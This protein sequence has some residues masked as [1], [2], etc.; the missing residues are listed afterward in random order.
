MCFD[1]APGWTQCPAWTW[2]KGG[3]G[4]QGASG[5]PISPTA[6]PAFSLGGSLATVPAQP[7]SDRPRGWGAGA[8]VLPALSPQGCLLPPHKLSGP[9]DFALGPRLASGAPSLARFVPPA[10]RLLCVTASV[11]PS[12]PPPPLPL[13][14]LVVLPKPSH[15]QSD[16]PGPTALPAPG[17]PFPAVLEA[18]RI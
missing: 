3:A 4:R 17:C 5:V 6:A 13:Q 12:Q 1:S 7:Q 15:P 11:C 2:G 16:S 8:L 14:D 9:Q 10:S 18:Q